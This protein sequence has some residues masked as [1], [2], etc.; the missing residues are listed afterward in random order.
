MSKQDEQGYRVKTELAVCGNCK[1]GLPPPP[2][3]VETCCSLGGFDVDR[4]YG[5]C[6]HHEWRR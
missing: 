5:T 3:V 4:H 6:R 1:H 2:C